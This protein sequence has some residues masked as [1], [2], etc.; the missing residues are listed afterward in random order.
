MTIRRA[1]AATLA[2]LLGGSATTAA[3]AL[4]NATFATSLGLFVLRALG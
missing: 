3:A 2:G 1:V 4:M